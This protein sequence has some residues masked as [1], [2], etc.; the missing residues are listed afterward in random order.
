MTILIAIIVLVVALLAAVVIFAVVG[1]RQTDKAVGRL[2][3]ETRRRDKQ[4]RAAERKA[5]TRALAGVDGA[6]VPA[7]WTPPDE[8]AVGMARRQFLNRG[9]V[10]LFATGLAVFGAGI[11][12]F[13]WPQG[14]GGFGSKISV[15]KISDILANIDKNNGFY[16]VPEGKMWLTRYPSYAL[17]KAKAVYVPAELTA[18]EAGVTVL[19]QKCPH[20]GCR[21]PQCLTSKWFECPCHG[22]QYNQVGEKKG[23]PA[24]RGMDRFASEVS[25]GSL[26]VD[27][28]TVILGPPIGTDT[29]GQEAEG[30]HCV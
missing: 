6:D 9:M 14:G 22:S 23:G 4:A 15:G 21:V 7:P 19:Y 27:T 29:T 24:P 5:A 12:E 17:T 28:G 18:M 2:T 30:P 13:L 10:T 11:L 3:L 25:G 8:R 16:Y 20:L 26:T 1:R